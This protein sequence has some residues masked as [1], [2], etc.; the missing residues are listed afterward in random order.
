VSWS[1]DA[2]GHVFPSNA[3]TADEGY[4]HVVIDRSGVQWS[5]REV[6]TPQA[7]ARAERCLVLNS[8]DC[9]RRVWRYP[10]TW[11][12]MDADSLLRLGTAD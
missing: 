2:A 1:V 4:P 3:G 11:R 5:V 7:W 12:S 6:H 10:P 8:R 9:V